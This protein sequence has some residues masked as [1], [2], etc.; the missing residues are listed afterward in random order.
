[1]F[2]TASFLTLLLALSITGSPVEVRNSPIILPLAR[3]L[4]FSNG[5]IDLV[6]HDKARVAALSTHDRRAESGILTAF[7]YFR[8]IAALNV[9]FPPRS[10][11]LMVDTGSSITWIGASTPYVRTPT[12]FNTRQGVRA[13]YGVG[14]FSASFSDT[15]TLG[16]GLTIPDYELAVASTSLNVIYDGVL[17]LGPRDLTVNTLTNNPGA[18]YPTFTDRLVNVGAIDHNIIG[19]FFRPTTGNQ[20]ND[21][22]ELSFGQPDYT[23]C[24]IIVLFQSDHQHP[25]SARYWGIDLSITYNNRV[26][27]FPTAGIIDTGTTLIQI[28][29]DAY[30][31]YQIATGATFD[32]PTG[33]LRITLDRY[34]DLQPLNFHMS[35][36]T[37]TLIPDAQI[38]PRALNGML[39]GD[40]DAIYLI[41][42][43]IGTATGRGFD[44][45]IGYTFMQRFYTVL[46]GDHI[47]VGF[48]TTPFTNLIVNVN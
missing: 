35:Q 48:A 2:L 36:Q 7:G 4:D 10:Y 40:N 27:L 19:I 31:R 34:N 18:T 8:Y 29:T 37:L 21:I 12:S 28:P 39:P 6:Q 42:G 17:G 45:M 32:E 13:N 44:F 43:N 30:R 14:G 25:P 15:V 3:R 20:D 23:K 46:Y 47:G 33:L 38:W 9:G 11:Y 22:G 41:I 26:I 16:R 24:T 1:M 5:T